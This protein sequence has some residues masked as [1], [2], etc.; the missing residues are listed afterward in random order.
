M[1]YMKLEHFTASVWKILNKNMVLVLFC[2]NQ[3]TEK[4]HSNRQMQN[5]Y[6][7]L[8]T[9][10]ERTIFGSSLLYRGDSSI[11]AEQIKHAR[12]CVVLSTFCCPCIVQDRDVCLFSYLILD[13]LP[14]FSQ[15][16]ISAGHGIVEESGINEPHQDNMAT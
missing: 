7:Y 13:V 2:L 6:R 10:S 12:T 9:G 1:L 14:I 3:V 11:F 4:Y 8:D 16:M 5:K 15:G